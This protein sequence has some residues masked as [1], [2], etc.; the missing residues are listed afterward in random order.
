M[1]AL[2]SNFALFSC[3]IKVRELSPAVS[4][5]HCICVCRYTMGTACIAECLEFD[6][7]KTV[8]V[9]VIARPG[10]AAAA[11]LGPS[12]VLRTYTVPGAP[13]FTFHHSNGF[14]TPD[15]KSLV[16]DTNAFG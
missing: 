12:K 8:K 4:M 16:V 14:E 1:R 15:G 5:C 2:S 10:S 6:S 3:C 11:R 9:H 13:F 7:K